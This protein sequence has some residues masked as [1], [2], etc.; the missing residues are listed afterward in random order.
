MSIYQLGDD[1]LTNL[2][3]LAPN[4]LGRKVD[5]ELIHT[6]CFISVKEE[7]GPISEIWRW[8]IIQDYSAYPIN[9]REERFLRIRGMFFKNVA[10]V[11]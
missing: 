11:Y 1:R 8:V 9:N 10:D 5:D 3:I 6:F 4:I 2:K 7:V